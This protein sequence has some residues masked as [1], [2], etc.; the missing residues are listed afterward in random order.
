M[1]PR[2]RFA[3]PLAMQRTPVIP[4]YN[5]SMDIPN[6]SL[7]PYLLAHFECRIPLQ[8]VSVQNGLR[9]YLTAGLPWSKAKD[10][11]HGCLEANDNA[12]PP[13]L[14]KSVLD[15]VRA[16]HADL[17]SIHLPVLLAWG[18]RQPWGSEVNTTRS[19]HKWAGRCAAIKQKDA[20]VF[21]NVMAFNG[22][23]LSLA[24]A[25][26]VALRAQVFAQTFERLT[27]CLR[28]RHAGNIPSSTAS[29]LVMNLGLAAGHAASADPSL[30]QQWELWASD[31]LEGLIFSKQM[32]LSKDIVNSTLPGQAKLNAHQKAHSILWVMARET[33]R[34]LLPQDDVDCF[35]HLPWATPDPERYEIQYMD[36]E[37]KDAFVSTN[38]NAT[39]HYCPTLYPFLELACHVDDWCDKEKITQWV[40]KFKTPGTPDSIPL[41]ANLQ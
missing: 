22:Q 27:E 30:M 28:E 15:N 18:L 29:T 19:M 25:I 5:R 3:Q 26:P 37:A 13:L 6:F 24:D 1:D 40:A 34:P 23:L 33:F 31:V 14:A 8:S 4:W 21:W 35:A 11:V 7:A 36:V 2:K 17:E 39:R 32:L 20:T 12:T 16:N 38:R 41:P 10:L 9:K